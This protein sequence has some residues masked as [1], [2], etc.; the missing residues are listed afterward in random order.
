MTRILQWPMVQMERLKIEDMADFD[1]REV[2]MYWLS[3][4]ALFTGVPASTVKRWTGQIGVAE[5]LIF[6]PSERF[7]QRDRE[8]R[9]SF[10]NLLEV[11][12]L[13][14]LRKEDI[15][16]ARIRTGLDYLAGAVNTPTKHPLLSHT[17]YTVPGMRDMFIQT[18]EGHPLNVSRHGQPALG[19]ILNAYLK[20]IQWDHTGPI[21]LMPMRTERV[22]ISLHVAGGQPVVRDTGI[23]ASMLAGRW[24]AGDGISELAED[25]SLPEADVREAVRYI[26]ASAA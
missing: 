22:V 13:D 24:T 14:A 1:P 9:L 10:A 11:H 8:L 25:Y 12:I 6:A 20:R 17:F 16:I 5:P 2:P 18:V 19:E 23:L 21:S 3:D 15:P 4:V 26:S 7:Q